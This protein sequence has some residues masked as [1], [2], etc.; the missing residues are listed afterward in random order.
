VESSTEV[1]KRERADLGPFSSG[2]VEVDSSLRQQ[3]VS[4]LH[5]Q[6]NE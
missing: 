5:S 6:S 3:K 2:D 4:Q 1:R